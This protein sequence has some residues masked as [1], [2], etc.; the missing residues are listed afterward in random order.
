MDNRHL[1][2][3][4]TDIGNDIDDAVCLA[5]LLAQPHCDLLGI[6]TVTA[7]PEQRAGLASVLCQTAG[8]R[9]PIFPGAPAPLASP[10]VQGP[11]PQAAALA[12]WAH[13][14]SFPA[15]EAVEFLRRTIRAHPGQ[16]TLLAIGPLTNV[17]LL[18]AVDPQIPSLLRSLVMMGGSFAEGSGPE[19]NIHCDPYAA[20][21]VYAAA[22][23][24]HRSIGLDVTTRVQMKADEFLRRCGDIPLL[25]PVADMAASWF[26]DRPEVTFHDP[27]AA[28]T[29]FDPALCSFAAG[30]VAVRCEG[31]PAAGIT[32]WRPADDV[33]PGPEA[34]SGARTE[35]RVPA[36]HEVALDVREQAFLDHYFA[37]VEAFSSTG[38][39]D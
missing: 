24:V 12:R 3:L 25:R 16:V 35:G 29:L 15:G 30:E 38:A 8:R 20:A 13:E 7:E 18:F 23:P 33:E 28:A 27:L 2:L 37:V 10:P 22:V 36:P 17:A 9:V 39:Q 14:D 1:V 21:R 32:T 6:T 5:Y 34:G 4:D 31:G 11:P 19:W 26:A